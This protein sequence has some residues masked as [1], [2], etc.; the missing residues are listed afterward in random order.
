MLPL[1]DRPIRFAVESIRNG[2]PSHVTDGV[3]HSPRDNDFPI[4]DIHYQLL[5][6]GHN[7]QLPVRTKMRTSSLSENEFSIEFNIKTLVAR[8]VEKNLG[9]EL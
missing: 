6:R 5:K 1:S 3:N 4:R 7:R 9:L 8:R 2:L